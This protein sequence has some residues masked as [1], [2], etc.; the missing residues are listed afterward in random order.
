MVARRKT[1]T[2][3]QVKLVCFL[4]LG[5]ELSVYQGKLLWN[6]TADLKGLTAILGEQIYLFPYLSCTRE[7]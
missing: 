5:T 4:W 6:E 1:F 7:K 2:N 3:V